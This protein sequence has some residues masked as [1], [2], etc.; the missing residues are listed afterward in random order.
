MFQGEQTQLSLARR[1]QPTARAGPSWGSPPPYMFQNK[2][3][4]LVTAPILSCTDLGCVIFHFPVQNTA[5]LSK[6]HES[7]PPSNGHLARQETTERQAWKGQLLL[8][9]SSS[10]HLPASAPIL[11][12]GLVIVVLGHSGGCQDSSC[13]VYSAAPTVAHIGLFQAYPKFSQVALVEARLSSS[14]A[15]EREMGRPIQGQEALDQLE[16]RRCSTS[17]DGK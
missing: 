16:S 15:K 10:H 7:S 13:S 1:E 14:N 9:Q 5:T 4:H 6:C 12:L 17:S 8:L 11:R 3:A 2:A